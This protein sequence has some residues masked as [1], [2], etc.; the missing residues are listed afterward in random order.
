[1]LENKWHVCSYFKNV[2]YDYYT[3]NIIQYNYIFIS[4]TFY[5]I[6]MKHERDAKN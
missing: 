4:N 2:T 6:I 5:F 3:C 1:M